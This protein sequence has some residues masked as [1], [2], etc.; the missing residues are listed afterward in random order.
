MHM[1][2]PVL[3]G[4]WLF[5]M[6]DKHKGQ[7]FC[8]D[9]TTGEVAWRGPDRA[10][11]NIALIK[12]GPVIFLQTD[13]A[14]LRI[15][16]AN[17]EAYRELVMYKVADSPTWAHPAI[18]GNAILIKDKTHLTAYSFGPSGSISQD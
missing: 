8:L 5:G 13:E 16:E 17:P 12:A 14:E 9:A 1:S 2:S 11:E 7:V 6:T 18:V 4:K 3:H 15:I 10:A